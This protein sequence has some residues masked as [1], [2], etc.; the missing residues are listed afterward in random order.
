[1]NDIKGAI[2]IIQA[3]AEVIKTL[4]TV[5]SGHLYANLMG[6][7]NLEQY[8]MVIDKLKEAKLIKVENHLITWIG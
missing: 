7:L 6:K 5:P 2:A 1:M 3:V 4:Q 8:Q